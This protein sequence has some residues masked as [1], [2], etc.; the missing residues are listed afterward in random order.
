M[1]N[2]LPK[3]IARTADDL[4]TLSEGVLRDSAPKLA[5]RGWTLSKAEVDSWSTVTGA[6]ADL[7]L[8]F[9]GPLGFYQDI[10]NTGL[11]R[12][13]RIVAT[14]D[15]VRRWSEGLVQDLA[16]GDSQ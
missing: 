3:A 1:S 15:E 5:A 13:G 4:R 10:R 14:E 2:G 6:A 8:Y 7:V 12:D 11:V 16:N 9:D